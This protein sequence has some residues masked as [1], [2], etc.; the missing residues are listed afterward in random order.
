MAYDAFVVDGS[1]LQYMSGTTAVNVPGVVTMGFSGGKK[2]TIDYT[3]ISDTAR[4]KK[5]GKPDY[6]Q[7][8]FEL[9]YDPADSAHEHFR[10]QY[11]S[12]GSTDQF[13]IVLT[14]NPAKTVQFN[15][16]ITAFDM[17]LAGDSIGKATGT[18]DLDGAWSFTA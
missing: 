2:T 7:F 14:T 13:K 16:S 8:N 17:S 15:G 6:G 9:A 10:S 18:I 11:A 12:A 4:K 5:G 3:A 1:Q